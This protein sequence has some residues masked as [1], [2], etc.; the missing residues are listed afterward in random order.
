MA[1]VGNFASDR[2]GVGAGRWG[3]HAMVMFGSAGHYN[4]IEEAN[5][6]EKVFLV[7]IFFLK[8]S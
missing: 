2:V 1:E 4:Y 5:D 6:M 7:T 3:G 8:L